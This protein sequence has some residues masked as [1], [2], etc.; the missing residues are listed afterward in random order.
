MK[1]HVR[2]SEDHSYMDKLREG[3]SLKPLT[4]D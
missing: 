4:D 3:A 2:F 1:V